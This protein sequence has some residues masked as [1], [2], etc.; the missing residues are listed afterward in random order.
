MDAVPWSQSN[1]D[2]P[3]IRK[4]PCSTFFSHYA[5]CDVSLSNGT[6]FLASSVGW[7]GKM[8][9]PCVGAVFR[10]RKRTT[11][12]VVEFQVSLYPSSVSPFFPGM[13]DKCVNIMT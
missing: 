4:G 5:G 3:Y 1:T 7:E 2:S 12:A 6:I 10:A 13:H 8:S 9:V 11:V